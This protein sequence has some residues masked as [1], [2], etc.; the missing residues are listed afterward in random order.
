MEIFL[1][2]MMLTLGLGVDVFYQAEEVSVF[3]LC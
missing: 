2:S 3:L 1:K